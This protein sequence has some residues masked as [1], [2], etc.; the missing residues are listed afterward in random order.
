MHLNARAYPAHAAFDRSKPAV[1]TALSAFW[2]RGRPVER[3]AYVVSV[4]L[5]AS[6]LVHLALLL[7]GDA[8]W[9]GPRSLRK[10]MTFGL[11][12]GLTTLTI[13]WVS[14]FLQLGERV[15]TWLLAWF[16][17]ASVLETALVS[18]QAWRGVPS[19]FNL[20]TT[21]DA[22]VTRMLAGGGITLVVIVVALTRLS[23]RKSTA[24][25]SLRVAIRVGFVALCVALLSGG[26]MIARGTQLVLAGNLE[27]AYAT[28]GSLRPTH[29][30]FMHGIL[31][32]P[33][34]AWMLSLVPMTEQRRLNLVMAAAVIYLVLACAIAAANLTGLLS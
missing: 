24:P 8:S 12:F 16:T 29:G 3:A 19:H 34:L 13:V 27:T 1:L 17:G 32:L 22:W 11:S 26:L 31:V 2:T 25:I 28:G 23:F 33:L 10:P 9:A 20:E 30:V 21:F 6:G 14:T 15:R 18:L 4:L 7:V 5:L